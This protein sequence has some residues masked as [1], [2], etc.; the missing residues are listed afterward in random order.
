MHGPR[1]ARRPYPQQRMRC[2]RPPPQIGTAAELDRLHRAKACSRARS[3][4]GYNEPRIGSTGTILRNRDFYT[5]TRLRC[6]AT[7]PLLVL[8]EVGIKPD[9]IFANGIRSRLSQM[10]RHLRNDS[11]RQHGASEQAVSGWPIP[12][13]RSR[14]ALPQP[15]SPARPCRRLRAAACCKMDLCIHNVRAYP[16]L[17]TSARASRR[18]GPLVWCKAELIASSER[19]HS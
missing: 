12:F 5:L 13:P 1:V 17:P 10:Y 6:R 15:Y 8:G 11:R 9:R 16:D 3:K 2:G 7:Q 18:S 19:W 4:S 14:E